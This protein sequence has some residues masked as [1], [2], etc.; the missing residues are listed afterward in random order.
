M[1]S[2]TSKIR[3]SASFSGLFLIL[4]TCSCLFLRSVF[5][6]THPMFTLASSSNLFSP[7]FS[8]PRLVFV[9]Q[10]FPFLKL[11]VTSSPTLVIVTVR[12]SR[13]T[14]ASNYWFS[15][16]VRRHWLSTT[17][18]IDDSGHVLP[19]NPSVGGSKASD[20]HMQPSLALF[21]FFPY[22]CL[23]PFAPD[24][25]LRVILLFYFSPFFKAK[26]GHYPIC[27]YLTHAVQ[28]L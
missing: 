8:P 27:S 23:C 20:S 24:F 26:L 15:L 11:S 28:L 13:K 19:E 9:R 25:S 4:T 6:L 18:V 16:A 14:A 3:L 7:L 22:I 17:A 5:P 10:S 12:C 2:L 1:F 21:L